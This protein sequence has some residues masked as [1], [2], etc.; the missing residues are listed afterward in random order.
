MPVWDPKLYL[1]FGGERTQPAIDL[2]S[3]IQLGEPAH[4]VDLGCGPGN[5][6]ELLRQRWPNADIAGVDNSPSMIEA[7]RKS[8][9]S[10]VWL[11][12]EIASWKP[13]APCDLV[14]SNA[15][16]HWLPNHATLFPALMQDVA[17]GGVLAV[18]MPA[19]FESPVHAAI[20]E[21]A[22]QSP[23]RSRMAS[24]QSAIRVERPGFYYDSLQPFVRRIEIW[25]T[26]YNH[27]MNG[28]EAILEW[29]RGTGLRPFLEALK[30]DEE[31]REFTD[32]Y[33][34]KLTATYPRQ[35]DGKVLFP[36]RRLF[37]LAHR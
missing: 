18:Q 28:P 24:A 11:E 25:E 4:I 37:I 22:E 20:I 10:G 19:H 32:R 27:V 9:P 2:L 8:R 12:G 36:F 6:T 30:D 16:L 3:R 34:K 1:K 35:C 29:I 14:F 31:R 15:A 5:S 23:W 33:L 26:L 13:S 17:L 7:A 21:I